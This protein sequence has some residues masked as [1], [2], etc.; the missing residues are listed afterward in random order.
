MASAS[1]S[2][3]QNEQ[4]EVTIALAKKESAE[5]LEGMA[6]LREWS[7]SRSLRAEAFAP[8]EAPEERDGEVWKTIHFVRHGQGFHNVMADVFF[9][10][11]REWEQFVRSPENPYVMPELLDAPLTHK[12]REQASALRSV[13]RNLDDRSRPELVVCSPNCRAL[14]TALLAFD[15]DDDRVEFLAHETAREETGVHVCDRRRP[16]SQQAREFPRVDFGLLESEEDVVFD[17]RRRETKREVGARAYR[18]LEWLHDERPETRCLAVASH[19]GWLFTLF[20]GVVDCGGDE[21]LRQWFHTGEMR[22]VRIRF[23]RRST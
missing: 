17:E 14:Q 3:F 11:G 18:L 9:A 16:T 15:D 1:S 4:D 2:S 5:H 8:S 12:G 10:A 22:T 6:E 7:D 13:V 20:N 23:T 21:S 19:S